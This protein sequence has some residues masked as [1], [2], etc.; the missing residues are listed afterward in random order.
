MINVRIREGKIHLLLSFNFD[1]QY[2]IHKKKKQTYFMNSNNEIKN[3]HLYLKSLYKIK[4]KGTGLFL[5]SRIVY[6]MSRFNLYGILH[7]GEKMI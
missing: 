1:S 7:G 6:R 5:R 2:R 4:K 3:R